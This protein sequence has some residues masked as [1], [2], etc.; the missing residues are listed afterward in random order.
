MFASLAF[1]IGLALLIVALV[2]FSMASCTSSTELDELL[3]VKEDKEVKEENYHLRE[4]HYGSFLRTMTLPTGV[5]DDLFGRMLRELWQR[6]SVDAQ[7]V[8]QDAEAPTGLYFVSH[9][10]QGHQFSYRR[11]GSAAAGMTPHWLHGGPAEACIRR[12][13]PRSS[14]GASGSCSC[15]TRGSQACKHSSQSA[16]CSRKIEL[17]KLGLKKPEPWQKRVLLENGLEW[18]A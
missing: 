13:R 18:S 14:C 3:E 16:R 11:A 8:E 17:R 15:S 6:E 1:V 5:G 4:R 9:G 7:A 12:A 10:P 2:Y